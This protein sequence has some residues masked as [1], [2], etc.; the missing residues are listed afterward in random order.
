MSER[1]LASSV[2]LIT[3]G[4]SG[5]GRASALAFARRGA[6]LAL[7]GR[8]A[9]ALEQTATESGADVI[10]LPCDVTDE[11]QVAAALQ[12][13]LA[14]FGR[15]DVLINCAGIAGP[16]VLTHHTRDRDFQELVRAFR[17]T[18]NVLERNDRRPYLERGMDRMGDLLSELS[19]YYGRRGDYRYDWDRNGWRDG[20]R[21]NGRN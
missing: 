17:E 20:W 19:G 6:R 21:G 15:I 14:R 4:G 10:C 18:G 11:A 12:A 1:T 5:I 7:L 9:H 16:A 3:G 13:C 2:V 8:R